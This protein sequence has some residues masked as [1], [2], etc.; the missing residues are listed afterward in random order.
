MS[1]LSLRLLLCVLCFA[2]TANAQK[3]ALSFAPPSGEAMAWN[4]DMDMDMHMKPP[5]M[6]TEMDMNMNMGIGMKLIVEEG[7]DK[8]GHVEVRGIVDSMRMAM[9]GMPGMAVNF[10][11][12]Q[13]STDPMGK[14]MEDALGPLFD[15]TILQTLNAKGEVV[16]TT[17]LDSLLARLGEGN[18]G[19]GGMS[20]NPFENMQSYI[21]PLP[22]KKVKVGASWEQDIEV[23]SNG[24]PIHYA[25]TYTFTGVEGDLAVIQVDGRIRMDETQTEQNGMEMT[26]SMQGTQKGT[27]KV[28]LRDGMTT[29]VDIAQI[30]TMDMLVMGM[31]MPATINSHIVLKSVNR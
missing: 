27:M 23:T 3:Y 13:P 25:N 9:G 15:A 6:D 8:Q 2:G 17:G 16:E 28:R 19:M 22:D 14:S 24:T 7:P 11:S 4:I 10:N 20:S 1:T 29:D 26:M 31:E 18:A 30:L 12:N 5:G 21:T